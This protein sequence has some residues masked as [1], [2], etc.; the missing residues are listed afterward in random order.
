MAFP[1]LSSKGKECCSPYAAQLLV[2]KSLKAAKTNGPPLVKANFA[3]GEWSVEGMRYPGTQKE[4][5]KAYKRFESV[6]H[7][8]AAE[9]MCSAFFEIDFLHERS[10]P[11][12]ATVLN[13][14]WS[15]EMF[16]KVQQPKLYET[17]IRIEPAVP[18]SILFP[19]I[20]SV[21]EALRDFFDGGFY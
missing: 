16:L 14:A 11:M 15:L 10:E 3:D 4:I 12:D 1:Y 6:G 9:M 18:K 2:E 7:I 13:S 8:I 5:R 21:D 17:L 19:E 20:V